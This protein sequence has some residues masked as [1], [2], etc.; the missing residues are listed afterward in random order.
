[1]LNRFTFNTKAFGLLKLTSKAYHPVRELMKKRTAAFYSD[2]Q[3]IGK[4][5]VKMVALHDKIQDP[6]KVT[7]GSTFEELGLDSLDMVD[8]I[9][10]IEHEY[11]YDFGASDWEQFLT[12][13]DIAQFMARDYF[14]QK[15]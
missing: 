10:E 4:E 9:S 12:I 6:S 15:H 3:E 11:K 7:I 14:A 1:M 2:P 8:V 5:I 13:N